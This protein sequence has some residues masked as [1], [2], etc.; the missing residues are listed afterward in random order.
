MKDFRILSLLLICLMIFGFSEEVNPACYQRCMRSIK[1]TARKP[2]SCIVREGLKGVGK[3]MS[4]AGDL[5]DIVMPGNIRECEKL[6]KQSS[7]QIG[8]IEKNCK[9]KCKSVNKQKQKSL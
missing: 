4:K 3:L 7:S 9:A 8:V 1:R 6:F 5:L 2:L